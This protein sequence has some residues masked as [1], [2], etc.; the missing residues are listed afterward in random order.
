MWRALV[1]MDL[2]G[3]PAAAHPPPTTSRTDSEGVGL[4]ADAVARLGS[5]RFWHAD[6]IH[7]GRFSPDGRTLFVGTVNRDALYAWDVVT[8]RLRWRTVFGDSA[9]NTTKFG[10]SLQPRDIGFIG[11]AIA[12]LAPDGQ[13]RECVVVFDP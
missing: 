7:P 6:Q 9:E 13:K 4:P 1:L 2:V 11:T 12:V 8:G 5:T 3:G 10:R